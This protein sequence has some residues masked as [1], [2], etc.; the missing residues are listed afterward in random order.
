MWSNK[1]KMLHI[2]DIQENNIT[3]CKLYIFFDYTIEEENRL[4][5]DLEQ[6][7]R[8]N[9]IHD[10]PVNIQTTIRRCME[11]WMNKL[12]R[13]GVL[14]MRMEFYFVFFSVANSWWCRERGCRSKINYQNVMFHTGFTFNKHPPNTHNIYVL[15]SLHGCYIIVSI[16]SQFWC[17]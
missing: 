7:L 17:G 10:T 9:R 6:I 1:G 8:L 12:T 14:M 15:L 16:V 3:S 11:G 5:V 2:H 4:R 13:D